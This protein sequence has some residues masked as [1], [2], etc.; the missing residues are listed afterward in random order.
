MKEAC[1]AKNINMNIKNIKI[2]LSKF[3]LSVIKKV[4]QIEE[5]LISKGCEY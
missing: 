2:I 5:A 1:N 3:T 4:N